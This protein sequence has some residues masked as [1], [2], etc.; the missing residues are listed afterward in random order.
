MT[1][2]KSQTDLL[3]NV[4]VFVQVGQCDSFTAA[5]RRLDITASGVSR[6]VARLEDRLGVQL[7]SRTTRSIS[8]TAEGEIYFQR[9]KQILNELAE[10]EDEINHSQTEPSGR[11]RVRLPKSFGR[12]VV[13]PVLSEFTDRYPKVNLDIRLMSGISDMV[14]QGVDVAMQLGKP[15]DARLVARKVC[16]ISYVLCA[17]PDY[18]RQHGTPETLSDLARHRCL[19]YIQPHSETPREWTLTENGQPASFKVPGAVN[20]DDLHALLDAA[21]G[22]VGIAYLMDFMIRRSVA[23]RRLRV[24]MPSFRHQG[25]TAYIVYPPSRFRASRVRAFVDFICGLVPNEET[26]SE[27]IAGQSQ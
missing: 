1:R 11:L 25:P 24:I 15:H 26:T 17:S 10:V 16:D 9:C 23:A 22:G 14:E 20:I 19:A 7:V 21:A 8:L 4:S 12:A 2:D 27:I 5:A 13:F 3:S 6:S 18:L